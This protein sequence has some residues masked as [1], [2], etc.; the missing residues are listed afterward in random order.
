MQEET[1]I[2]EV[3]D[4]W[5]GSYF[6]ESLTLQLEAAA[7]VRALPLCL[8]TSCWEMKGGAGALWGRSK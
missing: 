3:A 1:G 8:S 5:A 6:M 7:E 2:T 4:P